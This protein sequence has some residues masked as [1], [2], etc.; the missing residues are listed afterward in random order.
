MRRGN[1]S[2]L[3]RYLFFATQLVLAFEFFYYNIGATCLDSLPQGRLA[4]AGYTGAP[5]RWT[6][7]TLSIILS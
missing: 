1:A 2:A 6:S 5:P 7:L 3:P 4:L